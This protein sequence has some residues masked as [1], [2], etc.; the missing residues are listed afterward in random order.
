MSSTPRAPRLSVVLICY[1]MPREIPR[2]VRSLS[3]AMQTGIAEDDYEILLID[4]GST[5]PF[6]EDLCRALAPNLRVIHVPDAGPSPVA[7]IN[8][9]LAQARGELVGVFIDGARMA[10]PGLLAL[11]LAAARSHERPVVG[12]LA[13]HL[14]PDVQFR[15]IAQGYDQRVED[16]LL[17]KSGWDADGYRLFDIS[18]FAGSSQDGWFTIPAETN[19][20]FLPRALWQEL[21]GYDPG[22]VTPG[23]GLANLDLW[24]RACHLPQSQVIMLLGEGTFHQIHG[25]IATNSTENKWNYFHEEYVR[26]RGRPYQR[27]RVPARY[28]GTLTHIPRASLQTSLDRYYQ[29]HAS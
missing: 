10:S 27:P 28:Y 8:L 2:T 18:V 13:F 26:L 1:N 24:A 5:R 21:S 4:N 14:G 12:S 29:P 11:A 16:E 25:G 23:G 6:D 22:F 15:S 9:G 19:A 20:V 7:A 17:A 3:A